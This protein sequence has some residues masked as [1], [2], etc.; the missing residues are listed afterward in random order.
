[1]RLACL[2]ALA[3][4]IMA[5]LVGRGLVHGLLEATPVFLLGVAAR[6]VDGT[7]GA[8]LATI[9]ITTGIAIVVH[10]SNG[11]IEAHFL[12]FVAV[13]VIALYQSWKP[14]LTA[15][16]FVVLQ[17][18]VMGAVA[19]TT[20]YNHPAAVGNPWLWAGIHGAILL[21]ACVVSVTTWRIIEF[22][23]LH[24]A[25]THLAN[26]RLL[27]DRMEHAILIANRYGGRVGVLYVDVDAFKTINDSYGH[28]VGDRAL[29]HVAESMR[30]SARQSDTI[31][32]LGGDEFAILL[33][34]VDDHD[35]ALHVATRLLETV[36]R[37]LAVDGHDID[38][39]V[40]IGVAVAEGG[41]RAPD[42]LIRYADVALYSAKT[43]GKG[44]VAV[45]AC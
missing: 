1:V 33:P 7:R 15:V 5:L 13:G 24:D 21:S 3:L 11:S 14:F 10:L 42:D 44:K 36:A 45:V 38:V 40:S 34:F 12:Y 9:A 19:P 4:P 31:A 35:D 22:Q 28:G 2:Q 43:T 17:H 23:A 8:V 27:F 30:C 32:R 25:L 18:G 16:G 41:G 29:L 20:V 6:Q 39:R 37:P 26:R